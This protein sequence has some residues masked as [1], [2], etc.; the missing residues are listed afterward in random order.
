MW[1]SN[2]SQS[3]PRAVRETGA[4][5]RTYPTILYTFLQMHDHSATKKGS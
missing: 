4:V 5:F 3:L 1:E 2:I